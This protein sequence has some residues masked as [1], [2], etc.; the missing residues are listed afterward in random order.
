VVA[1]TALRRALAHL[2]RDARLGPLISRVDREPPPPSAEGTHFAALA[3][4]IVYQQ[5]SGKAAA[6][7]LARV[8]AAA[9][10]ALTAAAVAAA[11][12]DAL[13]AAGLSKQKLGYLRDLTAKAIS[14]ELPVERLHELPD[15]EIVTAVRAVKGIGL[16]T[17]QMFLMFRLGRPD[18]LPVHDLGIR[19]GVKRLFRLR[20]L[21]SPERIE[22]LA[23]PWRPYRSVAC[24]YLWRL[25][26][27]P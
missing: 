25:T 9:G 5:L 17:A 2:S 14:G 12:D 4:A 22:A 1:K 19:K 23:E 16:W 20:A 8:V 10:G 24:W 26:E 21:P 3:R 27:L 6:T 7:I 18:V 11:S 13:R 15:E